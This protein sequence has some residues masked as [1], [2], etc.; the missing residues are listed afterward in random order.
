MN[1]APVGGMVSVVNG[2]RYEGGEFMPVTGLFCGKGK[3]KVSAAAFE[4]AKVAL[5][6]KGKGL[7]YDEQFAHFAVL[8]PGGNKLATAANLNTLKAFWA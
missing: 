4:A 7:V 8:A 2:Q 1:K 5:A 3:N 6:L